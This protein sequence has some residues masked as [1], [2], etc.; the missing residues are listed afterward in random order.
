MASETS[1]KFPEVQGGGSLI[2]AWQIKGKTVLVVGGGEVGPWTKLLGSYC[3][4]GSP[5][6][7]PSRSPPAAF[8]IASTLMPMLP[9]SALP[10]G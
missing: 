3:G 7:R 9:S 5:A 1:R 4:P 10:L 8:S 2:L 6:D